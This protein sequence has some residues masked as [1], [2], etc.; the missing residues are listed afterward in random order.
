[1]VLFCVIHVHGGEDPQVAVLGGSTSPPAAAL[2]FRTDMCLSSISS[3]S[4][5][6]QGQPEVL[7]RLQK[8]DVYIDPYRN[9]SKINPNCHFPMRACFT[10]NA[11]RSLRV[12]GIDGRPQRQEGCDMDSLC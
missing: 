2:G 7:E 12:W 10:G 3:T 8:T 5:G 1:M 4:P 11:P 6:M 9:L